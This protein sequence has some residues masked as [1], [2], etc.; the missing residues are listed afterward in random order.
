SIIGPS[1][2]HLLL[3]ANGANT[4]NGGTISISSSSQMTV[5]S[6]ASAFEL[7]AQGGSNL[8]TAGNGGTI[9]LSAYTLGIDANYL[10]VNP[11]GQFGDGGK[12]ILTETQDL[13]GTF[14]VGSPSS[15]Y[16]CITGT[17]NAAA[18]TSGGNGGLIQL[19]NPNS[20]AKIF[21]WSNLTVSAGG[22]ASGG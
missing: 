1:S 15:C 21:S 2:G 22:S 4:G 14:A 5:G 18:A 12:I 11:L 9:S 13:V 8:S 7:F 17:L 6:G 20:A 3:T 10:Q 16:D 19:S